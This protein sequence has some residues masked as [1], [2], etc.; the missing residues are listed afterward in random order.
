M[1]H[2]PRLKRRLQR[3]CPDVL[4]L[5]PVLSVEWPERRM[6]R[7]KFLPLPQQLY[8]PRLETPL[9]TERRLPWVK[10]WLMQLR[11]PTAQHAD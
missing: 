8:L 6:P 4:S 1:R 7:M 5:P 2:S 11:L 9:A 3:W 10:R